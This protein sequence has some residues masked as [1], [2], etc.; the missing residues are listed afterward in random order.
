MVW[1]VF[2]I[3]SIAPFVLNGKLKPLLMKSPNEWKF[4]VNVSAV[5]VGTSHTPRS[6]ENISPD[7]DPAVGRWKASSTGTRVPIIHIP[8][9]PRCKLTEI[10]TCA[11]PSLVPGGPEHDD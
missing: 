2:A 1:K 9:W 3:N 10:I 4:I 6:D 5:S 11:Q 8:T 7:I